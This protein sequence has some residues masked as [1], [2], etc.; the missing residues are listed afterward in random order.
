MSLIK[1]TLTKYVAPVFIET[2]TWLGEG[3]LAAKEAG[4]KR[5]IS[6]EIS[7]KVYK[8][9]RKKFV[10]DNNI[11][12]I[13]GDSSIV[14]SNIIKNVEEKIT[15]VLDAHG[16]EYGNIVGQGREGLEQW[17]LIKELQIIAQHPRN[18]H[19]II[20]DDIRLLKLFNTSI[21]EVVNILNKINE[22]YCISL[23]D[24]LLEDNKIEAFDVLVA[25]IVDE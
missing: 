17:P 12:I 1:N 22:N 9:A 16:F 18:D 13:L 4:F 10:D 2:G 11:E 14:L 21:T 7:G 6:I 3:V 5:I 15:F 24:G 8:N 20:I 19:T 25:E 23:I